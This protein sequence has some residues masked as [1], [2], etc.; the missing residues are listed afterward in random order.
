MLVYFYKDIIIQTMQIRFF[1]YFLLFVLPSVAYGATSGYIPKRFSNLSTHT[2]TAVPYML[3]N[4]R[5]A[6]IPSVRTN[7]TTSS[8]RG[9]VQRGKTTARAMTNN[10]TYINYS[11]SQN[12]NRRV[13]QRNNSARATATNTSLRSGNN[14]RSVV[15]SGNTASRL[16]AAT[17]DT[18]T[19][20]E[21]NTSAQRC[22]A[23][24]KEC[25][26][27]YCERTDTAY[28]RCYCSAKLAQIDSQYQ[29][30]IDSLI[31]QIIR[32]QYS[33]Q[34]TSDDIKTYWND[35]VGIYTN[36]NPWVNI[37]NALN[38][39]W[40]DN[41]SRVRG[42]NAFNIGHQYCVQNLRSCYYM[43]SNLRDAYKSEIARDCAEYENGLQRIQMAAE[44]V[45]ENYND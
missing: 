27:G 30:E 45:I 20:A 19:Y 33:N 1:V 9:V 34:T 8:N 2:D 16:R 32:L 17:T 21:V 14:V 41:E 42:Q 7:T 15:V 28:N 39:D 40:A 22:F 12:S 10:G 26:D 38:I 11:N 18:A 43:A 24:Y 6:T 36:T 29:N 5:P 31:Q 35:T 25:M 3:N 44:S 23:D 4:A 13:V 37:D